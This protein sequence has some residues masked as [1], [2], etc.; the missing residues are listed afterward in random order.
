[1]DGT[2]PR[3]TRDP[4]RRRWYSRWRATRFARHLGFLP[5]PG[6]RAS[7]SQFIPP[8]PPPPN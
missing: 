2:R 6:P 4:A 5:Q 3:R 1:M 8:P 7:D